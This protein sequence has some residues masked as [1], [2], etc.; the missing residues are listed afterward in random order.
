MVFCSYLGERLSLY[1]EGANAYGNIIDTNGN[2]IISHDGDDGAVG[3]NLFDY[4]EGQA[5]FDEGYASSMLRDNPP[6]PPDKC[7]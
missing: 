1:R 7:R 3:R 4:L 2:Y 6:S 5:E